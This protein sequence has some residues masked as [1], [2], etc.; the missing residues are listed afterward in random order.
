[1][2]FKLTQLLIFPF[3]AVFSFLSKISARF[4]ISLCS[5]EINVTPS[6]LYISNLYFFDSSYFSSF[7]I[8]QYSIMT[9]PKSLYCGNVQSGVISTPSLE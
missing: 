8:P 1:M 2:H 9:S 7:V 3:F 6:F 4:L 5:I